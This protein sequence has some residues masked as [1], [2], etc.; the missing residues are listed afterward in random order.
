MKFYVTGPMSGMPGY[1]REAFVEMAEWLRAQGHEVINPAELDD[2]AEHEPYGQLLARDAHVILTDEGLEGLV[3]LPG[4]SESGGSRMEIAAAQA[5]QL[6][7]FFR[8]G[9]ELR[10]IW[11][12]AEWDVEVVMDGDGGDS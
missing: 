7:L 4:W 6:R 1:N 10:E 11:V 9:D 3:L 5:V 8:D 2:G 12:A